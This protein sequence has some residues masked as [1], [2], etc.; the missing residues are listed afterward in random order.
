[1]NVPAELIDNR[2]CDSSTLEN[3]NQVTH[4]NLPTNYHYNMAHMLESEMSYQPTEDPQL[5]L[6][7]V[8]VSFNLPQ[9]LK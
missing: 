4:C 5:E 2:L 7:S 1:M 9:N 6:D 3:E 8:A